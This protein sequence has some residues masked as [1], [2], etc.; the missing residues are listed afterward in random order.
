M[1]IKWCKILALGDIINSVENANANVSLHRM[2]NKLKM[3]FTNVSL[4][5]LSFTLQLDT[6]ICFTRKL[7]I[8][9]QVEFLNNKNRRDLLGMQNKKWLNSRL[10]LIAFT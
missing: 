6:K 4:N 10:Y 8:G 9:E 5:R 2:Q 7:H 1:S 3:E